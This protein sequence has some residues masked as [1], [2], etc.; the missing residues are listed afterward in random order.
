MSYSQRG[1]TL[2]EVI[3][4][5]AII[6]VIFGLSTFGAVKL[7]NRLYVAPADTGLINIFSTAARKSRDGSGQSDWGVYLPY[8]EISR[9]LNEI[10]VFKGSS[11]ALRDS[12]YDVSYRFSDTTLFVDVSLSGA[13]PSSG[14]DHEIVFS[15]LTGQTD[16]YGTITLTVFG[17]ERVVSVGEDGI[18]TR[19]Y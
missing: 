3:L 17:Q 7:S 2:I 18:P 13:S 8:N 12:D 16:N 9:A 5:V 4:S 10:I 6:V 11:Y 14:D 1:F 15:V 19:E